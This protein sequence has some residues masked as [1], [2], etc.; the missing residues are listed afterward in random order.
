MLCNLWYTI[1]LILAFWPFDNAIFHQISLFWA[2]HIDAK[3]SEKLM[4]FE[5]VTF[6]CSWIDVKEL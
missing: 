2:F 3:I 1:E 4:N 5:S 6:S